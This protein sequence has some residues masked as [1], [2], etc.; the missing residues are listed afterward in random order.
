MDDLEFEEVEF[1]SLMNECRTQFFT[2]LNSVLL[3]YKINRITP[4][5][6]N[7]AELDR[8]W[9]D[10]TIALQLII[11]LKREFISSVNTLILITQKLD[12]DIVKQNTVKSQLKQKLNALSGSTESSIGMLD[13]S[14]LIRTHVLYGNYLIACI[15]IFMIYKLII[16]YRTM[17][18]SK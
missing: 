1:N 16:L 13:N 7:R 6:S 8:S 11:T 18:P 4:T 14:K 3:K 10:L 5:T 2:R 15:C 9:S 12:D 17:S